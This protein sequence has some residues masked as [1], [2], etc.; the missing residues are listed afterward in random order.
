MAARI[1]ELTAK[2]YEIETA[3]SYQ[4]ML[5]VRKKLPFKRALKKMMG[6]SE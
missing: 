2:L 5:R 6:V 3:P 4:M 1:E